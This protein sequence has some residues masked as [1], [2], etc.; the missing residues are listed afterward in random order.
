MHKPETSPGTERARP[1]RSNV[2]TAVALKTRNGVSTTAHLDDFGRRSWPVGRCCRAAS[3][4]GFLRAAQ[5]DQAGHSFAG[6][7]VN[8]SRFQRERHLEQSISGHAG[9][10]F[11]VGNSGPETGPERVRRAQPH[12]SDLPTQPSPLTAACPEGVI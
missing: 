3:L 12:I 9:C 8:E 11:G 4:C 2:E 10:E 6:G 7:S 1:G 5:V